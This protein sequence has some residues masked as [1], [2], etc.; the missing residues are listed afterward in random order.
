QRCRPGSRRSLAMAKMHY[1][2]LGTSGLKVSEISLGTMMFGGPTSDAEARR[3]LDYGLEQG[4][5]FVDTANVYSETRSESVIGEAIKT[6]R[7]QWI[8]ST[9]VGNK[10]GSGMHDSGLSRRHVMRAVDAS[11]KRLQTDFID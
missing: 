8:V 2:P 7:D 9:K 4:V 5:N 10:V 6:K 1:R 3:M 11:L